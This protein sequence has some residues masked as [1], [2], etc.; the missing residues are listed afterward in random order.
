MGMIDEL[1]LLVTRPLVQIPMV[2][3][4]E[5]HLN[6]SAQHVATSIIT[7]L[8]SVHPTALVERKVAPCRIRPIHLS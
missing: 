6:P 2:S 5:P 4:G 3:L 7:W 1:G 8:L